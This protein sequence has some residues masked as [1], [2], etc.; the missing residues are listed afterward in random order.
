MGVRV[1]WNDARRR[2]SLRLAEGS[3]M[4]P[5]LRREIDVR[6]VPGKAT[7]RLVFAGGPLQVEI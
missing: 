7:R 6:T 5:P 2:L 1:E 3:R 4:R